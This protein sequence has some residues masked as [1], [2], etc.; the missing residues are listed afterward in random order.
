MRYPI[1][2]VQKSC[3]CR[4]FFR[5]RTVRPPVRRFARAP[6]SR[7]APILLLMQFGCIPLTAPGQSSRPTNLYDE[8]TIVCRITDARLN[9]ASGLVASR[10]NVDL[11]Y[12]HNDSGGKPIVYVLDR[13][14]RIVAE[15]RLVGAVNR[16]WE[17]IGLA[18]GGSVETFDVCVADI[19]DNLARRSEIEIYRFPEP[20]ITPQPSETIILDVEP[21]IYRAKYEDGSRN[22]EGFVVDPLTGDGYVLS[23]REDG[24]CEAY[25][26]PC[27]WSDN[28]TTILKRVAYLRF[29]SAPALATMVT[30]ADL[31]PD[32]RR[33]AT[34]SYPSGWEWR[35]PPDEAKPDFLKLIAQPPT[36]LNLA[37]ERQGEGICYS[38]DGSAI[39]TISEGTPTMLY[40]IRSTK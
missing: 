3:D 26:L 15:I 28:E 30:A 5:T 20:D 25:R 10:R 7:A 39:L 2:T 32:G 40:E 27:P 19:G 4:D 35:L 23:K 31:S 11:Y 29:P 24:R 1:R 34:R 9:E 37:V 22:A 18:P 38:A 12:T 14:G 33:L 36:V 17:D 8:P 16:D 21:R 13:T 6:L